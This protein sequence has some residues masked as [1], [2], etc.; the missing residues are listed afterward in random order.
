MNMRKVLLERAKLLGEGLSG[1]MKSTGSGLTGG[2]RRKAKKASGITGGCYSCPSRM[3][4]GKKKTASKKKT[5]TVPPQLKMWMSHVKQ[6]RQMHPDKPYKMILKMAS[7][8][9]K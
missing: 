2:R 8:S 1:D 7:K 5:G 4:G 3:M 6:V 9:Y